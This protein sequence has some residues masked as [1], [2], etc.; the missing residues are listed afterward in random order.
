MRVD[1]RGGEGEEGRRVGWI[2]RGIVRVRGG[3]G[4][5]IMREGNNDGEGVG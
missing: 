1:R 3:R 4:G 5:R 2:V